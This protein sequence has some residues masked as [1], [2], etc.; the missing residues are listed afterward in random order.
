MTPERMQGLHP[1]IQRDQPTTR[2]VFFY[3]GLKSFVAPVVASSMAD[4]AGKCRVEYRP[5]A[6]KQPTQIR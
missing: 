4:M 2:V 1:P 5:L 6:S 3:L